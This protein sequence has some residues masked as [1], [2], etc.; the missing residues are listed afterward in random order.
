MTRSHCLR[1]DSE[2]DLE[3]IR[4]A[5]RE[6][7]QRGELHVPERDIL[8]A[9]L[10]LLARHPRVAWAKRM[11]SGVTNYRDKT[12]EQRWVRY[13]FPGCPD[14]V[15]QLRTGQMLGIECKSDTGRPTDEQ[16][17]VLDTINAAGGLAFVA[18]SVDD[19]WKALA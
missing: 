10:E 5:R 8:A 7:F 17:A 15:G 1:F 6:R 18:R 12:G 3:R 4:A 16:Q 19:V 9:V 2:L 14:I 11:N 13:G